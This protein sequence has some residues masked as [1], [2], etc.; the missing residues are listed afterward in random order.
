MLFRV[1]SQPKLELQIPLQTEHVPDHESW[2]KGLDA[3]ILQQPAI[4]RFLQELS[5]WEVRESTSAQA[6]SLDYEV[7]Q[8]SVSSTKTAPNE[9]HKKTDTLAKETVAGRDLPASGGIV[10][11]SNIA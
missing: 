8:V 1:D 3:K 11:L 7:T 2:G 4:P 9:Q 5:Q 10:L 6:S